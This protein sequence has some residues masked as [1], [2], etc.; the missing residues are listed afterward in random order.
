MAW[1]SRLLFATS[2]VG[3]VAWVAAACSVGL[4]GAGSANNSSDASVVADATF[5]DALDASVEDAFIGNDGSQ[6]V[7]DSTAAMEDVA[8][9][10]LRCNGQCIDAADCTSC[11]GATLQCIPQGVCTGDCSA[12]SDLQNTPMPIQC[13][14]C[15]IN[16]ENPIGTCRY[17]DPSQF[18]LSGDY[19]MTYAGGT[20]GYRCE[21]TDGGIC[22][23]AT[24]VCTP[25]GQSMFCLTCGEVTTAD[26]QGQSCQG[27]GMC[28]TNTDTCQ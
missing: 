15:D 22:P 28:Q 17:D 11:V 24:Q 19:V 23:G 1:P 12:C 5:L 20:T 7:V 9:S 18:C 10:G 4:S 26:L 16:H 3:T 8:C 25:L 6:D 14:S 13:F 27:G 2:G 21:C